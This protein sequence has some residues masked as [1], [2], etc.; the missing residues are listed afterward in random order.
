[1]II[2]AVL[3]GFLAFY[4]LVG[5]AADSPAEVQWLDL[6]PKED[7]EAMEKMPEI[8]HDNPFDKSTLPEVMFSSR[9]VDTYEQKNIR[10]A[11]YMVPLEVNDEGALTEFF[12]A[13]YMG[14]C[15]HV[16]P[17]PPNQMI[18][19]TFPKGANVEGIWYPF[20]IEGVLS[21]ETFDNGLG[22]ASYSM[23]A[24]SVKAY[25]DY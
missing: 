6:M 20:V 17:P 22:A 7:I 1:M 14:A 21:V 19:V 2:N 12:L 3:S 10:I 13:P 16:P 25:E 8:G 15:I 4:S 11:G 23:S 18:H 9:V 24:T 5:M